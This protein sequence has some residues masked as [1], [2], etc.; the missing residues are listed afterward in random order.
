MAT[1]QAPPRRTSGVWDWVTSSVTFDNTGAV[2]AA[3]NGWGGNA[4]MIDT[5]AQSSMAIMIQPAP[6]SSTPGIGR[7]RVDE[8][9]GTIHICPTTANVTRYVAW[10]GIYVTDLNATTTLWNA[11]DPSVAVEACRDDFL[12]LEAMGFTGTLTAGSD[13][14]VMPSFDLK[15]SQPVVIGGGQGVAVTLIVRAVDIAGANCRAQFN[16]RARVGPVA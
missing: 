14:L 16:Y 13:P 10:C 8:I 3:F 1:R 6:A 7:L 4:A 2:G 9:R 12:F 5:L 11:R 15:L